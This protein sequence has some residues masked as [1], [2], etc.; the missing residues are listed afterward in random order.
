MSYRGFRLCCFAPTAGHCVHGAGEDGGVNGTI[1]SASAIRFDV[2]SLVGLESAIPW[3]C[4]QAFVFPRRSNPVPLGVPVYDG[5]DSLTT[6][7]ISR[8]E[9]LSIILLP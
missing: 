2:K 3:L 5:A 9:T 4:A 7:F 8:D 6:G 1:E